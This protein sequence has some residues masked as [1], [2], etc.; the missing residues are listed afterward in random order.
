MKNLLKISEKD[1][2]PIGLIVL[3][4]VSRLIPHPP[5]FTPIIAVA[6]MS[7]YFFKNINFSFIVLFISMVI[8]D[9]IIGFHSNIIFVYLSLFLITF[10]FFKLNKKINLKSLFVFGLLGS[11]MF[12]LISN[13]GVWLLTDM[14]EKSLNGLVSC[15][16]LAIPF[17]KNTF[18]ST[19]I[20]SYTPFLAYS[21]Y[22][23]KFI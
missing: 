3:L 22:K 16:V 6:I 5:N 18:L 1:I 4:A 17:F 23:K 14:Y 19:L 13:F 12:F 7:S 15:Y 10:I 9:A 2:F 8:S 20:F 11:V 21:F